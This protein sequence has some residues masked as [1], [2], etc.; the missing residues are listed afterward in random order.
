MR[1]LLILSF[2]ALAG[3]ARKNNNNNTD[4]RLNNNSN[5]NKD[6]SFTINRNEGPSQRGSKLLNVFNIVKF[7][8]DGCTSSLDTYG[9]CYSA[10]ECASRGGTSSGSCASGFGVCCTFQGSCG[11]STS[12]NNTYFASNDEDSSPCTFSVCKADDDICLIRLNFDTFN[13]AQ[14]STNYPE[15]NNPNGRTQ[16]QKAQFSANSAGP[17]APV[18]CGTNTGYHMILEARDDCNTLSFTWTSASPRTWNIQIMQIS[19]TAAWRPTAGCLQWF[20][21]S[22]GTIASYNYAGG[23]HLANQE[24]TNC[25]RAEQGKCSISYAATSSTFSVNLITPV[26]NPTNTAAVGQDCTDDYIIVS[27]GGATAGAST[28]YDRFCGGT[29]ALSSTITAATIYTNK[30]PFQVGVHFDATELD[31]APPPTATAQGYEWSKGFSLY[32]SQTDC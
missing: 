1:V 23:V 29:L 13:I 19:C 15:D 16:C 9:V 8:N 30:L 10:S 12:V 7:P 4:L 32:Y 3:H 6:R 22:T 25:I 24:Y 11:G 20:T 2:L 17:S 5:N 14:P 31:S 21:G 27:G 18:I 28:N 26:A